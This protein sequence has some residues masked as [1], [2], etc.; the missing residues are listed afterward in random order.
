MPVILSFLLFFLL[1]LPCVP[2]DTTFPLS[3]IF[4]ASSWP[5]CP[6]YSLFFCQIYLTNQSLSASNSSSNIA[7][8]WCETLLAYEDQCYTTVLIF[9]LSCALN[10]SQ[11]HFYLPLQSHFPFFFRG[12]V[13]E[14]RAWMLVIG[15]HSYPNFS[16]YYLGELEQ[17]TNLFQS[18]F[19]YM[20]NGNTN[21]YL[22][23]FSV[24]T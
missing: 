13:A 22:V 14:R 5:T 15:L 1:N 4:T 18:Q 16:T 6:L 2:M 19:P 9:I 24:K 20:K 10:T 23:G 21:S 11:Y 7:L 12:S 8:C 17:I 3:L